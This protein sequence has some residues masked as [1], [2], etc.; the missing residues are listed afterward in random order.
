[1][2]K[3]KWCSDQLAGWYS[4]SIRNKPILTA[5]VYGGGKVDIS[6]PPCDGSANNGRR[7]YC[8]WAPDGAQTTYVNIES[9]TQEWE[10]ADDLGDSHVAFSTR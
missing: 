9:I 1:M 5:I 8:I 6:V 2:E 7:G 3:F 4:F 10:M